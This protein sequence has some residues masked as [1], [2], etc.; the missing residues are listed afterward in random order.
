MNYISRLQEKL[1]DANA[2]LAAKAEALQEFRVHLAGDKFAGFEP[3]GGRK[4]SIA[5]RDVNA[6]LARIATAEA[7]AMTTTETLRVVT[8]PRSAPELRTSAWGSGR[9]SKPDRVRP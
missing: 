4:D 1:A 5:V 6:W 9:V 7:R 2:S 3:D 8:P